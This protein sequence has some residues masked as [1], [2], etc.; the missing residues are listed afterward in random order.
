MDI[1]VVKQY[2]SAVIFIGEVGGEGRGLGGKGG[3][4][5]S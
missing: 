4:Q 5:P 3:S 1:S 2:I